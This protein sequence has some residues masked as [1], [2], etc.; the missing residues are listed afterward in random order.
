FGSVA[1]HFQGKPA[2]SSKIEKR[3]ENLFS[4]LRLEQRFFVKKLA[5]S[6][7]TAESC[8]KPCCEDSRAITQKY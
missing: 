6:K 4:Y 3:T 5:N 2:Y 7:L 8:L 1:K